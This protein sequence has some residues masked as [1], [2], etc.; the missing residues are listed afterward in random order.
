M[1]PPVLDRPGNRLTKVELFTA[2]N[3]RFRHADD[4]P[5]P[6]AELSGMLP[7]LI[8]QWVDTTGAEIVDV[9]F[10]VNEYIVARTCTTTYTAL[11]TY[12]PAV[13]QAQPVRSNNGQVG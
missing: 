9:E 6:P 3:Q 12:V 7:L 2:S 8:N 10:C 1:I 11:V 4:Q 5:F 13:K